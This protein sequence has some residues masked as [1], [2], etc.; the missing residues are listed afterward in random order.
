MLSV[1][2]GAVTAVT[3][4]WVQSRD[5]EI[6]PIHA[7]NGVSHCLAMNQSDCEVTFRRLANSEEIFFPSDYSLSFSSARFVGVMGSLTF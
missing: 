7:F 5:K 2:G 1:N 4:R 3:L 6:L